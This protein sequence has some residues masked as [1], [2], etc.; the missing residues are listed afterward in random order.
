MRKIREVRTKSQP[1]IYMI[2]G[3]KIAEISAPQ[4]KIGADES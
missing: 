2:F 4:I 1:V 3:D